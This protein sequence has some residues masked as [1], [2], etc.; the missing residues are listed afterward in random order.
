MS[1]S[2]FL[3]LRKMTRVMS[4]TAG[5]RTTPTNNSPFQNGGGEGKGI[6]AF[7]VEQLFCK[8]TRE[9]AN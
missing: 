1:K 8:V 7:L 9:E 5:Y 2:F 4:A 3:M 6:A